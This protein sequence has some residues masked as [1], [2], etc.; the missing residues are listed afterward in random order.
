MARRFHTAL[1]IALL[2][3]YV[4]IVLH[5]DSVLPGLASANEGL[6]GIARVP[7]PFR[8]GQARRG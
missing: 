1:G 6:P 8:N 5:L 3:S 7:N 4:Y 2:L